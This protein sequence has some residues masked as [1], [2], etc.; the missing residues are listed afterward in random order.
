MTELL[1][2]GHASFRLV[3][4]ESIV[5]YIDPY[6]GEGYDVPAD[7]VFCSHEHKDHSDT[8]KVLLKDS[9]QIFH[10]PQL[11]INGE[12]QTVRIGD[13]FVLAVPAY[14]DKHPRETTVG[15]LVSA[16][17]RKMYFA[18]DTNFIPE[19]KELAAEKIDYA[20]FPTDGFFN[21]GPEEAGECAKAVA[22]VHSTPIHTC[23]NTD[24]IFKEENAL[25]F[26]AEGRL[27]LHP[28]EKITW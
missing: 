24:G 1:Y 28:G 11:L 15:L 17:G 6:A 16:G 9:A 14:N 21:M 12:Y 27:I 7:A 8:E 13:V 4:P 10:Y 3:S 20:F 18:S 23:K 2:Q 5:I 22:A 26:E 25:I 19:M